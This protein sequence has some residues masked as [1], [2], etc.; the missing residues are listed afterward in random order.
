MIIIGWLCQKL[1]EV[2]KAAAERLSQALRFLGD[3]DVDDQ[4]EVAET[5]IA[6]GAMG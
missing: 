1:L 4:T 2:F 3:V 6:Y 5:W